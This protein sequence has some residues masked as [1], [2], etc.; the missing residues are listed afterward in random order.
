VFVVE[1]FGKS[2]AAGV[3]IEDENRRIELVDAGACRTF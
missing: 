1:E 2:D 3:G